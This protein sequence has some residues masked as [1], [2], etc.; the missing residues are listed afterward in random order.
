ML[1]VFA[2]KIIF[3]VHTIVAFLPYQKKEE[4]KCQKLTY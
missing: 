2:Y 3:S 1:H 4:N